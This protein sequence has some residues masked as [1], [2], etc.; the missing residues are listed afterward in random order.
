MKLLT[1][2]VAAALLATSPV[3]AHEFTLGELVLE[4]PMIRE[5]PP[6][7]PVLA[8][9][10]KITNNGTEPDR[11]I[12]IESPAA[13]SV[14]LH[15]SVVTDGIAKMT[16]MTEGLLIGAGDTVWLG[17]NGTHAMFNGPDRRYVDG[18]EVPATLT[19]EKAGRIDVMFNV[20]K[21]SKKDLAPGHEG[22]DMGG[23]DAG[24]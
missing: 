2:A 15:I 17:E 7:A 11:L 9:Y 5:A 16:P 23:A 24:R 1:L 14:Q 13:K 22:M 4:H 6:S 20:E 10:V 12:A 18:D 3:Y 21:V 8:G 19:F